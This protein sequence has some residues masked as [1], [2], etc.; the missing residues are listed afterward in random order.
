MRF[1]LDPGLPS[2]CDVS[3]IVSYQPCAA[4]ALHVEKLWYCDGHQRGHGAQQVLLPDG[5]FQLVI[6]LAESPIK[7]VELANQENMRRSRERTR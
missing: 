1:A 7:I 4:L 6:S 5:Q 2:C 3:V